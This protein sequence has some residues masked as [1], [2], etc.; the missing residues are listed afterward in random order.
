MGA[1]AVVS[2]EEVWQA[3]LHAEARQWLHEHFDRWLDQV[4]RRMKEKPSTLNQL[5]Q[6]VLEMRQD[7]LGQ[8]TQGLVEQAH[9]QTLAQDTAGCPQCGR[10]LAARGPVRRTVQTLVGPVTLDRPDFYCVPCRAGFSPLDEALELLPQRKPGDIQK[11]AARLATAVPDETAAE[12]FEALTGGPS[13][14]THGI[15][16]STS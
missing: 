7:L 14:T 5:T 16:W 1:A 12:L 2:L 9:R 11:A 10:T 4:E 15:R 13:V 3:R 6:T 8:V